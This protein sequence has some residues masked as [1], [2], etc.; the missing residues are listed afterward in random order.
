MSLLTGQPASSFASMS[1]PTGTPFPSEPDPTLVRSAGVRGLAG[2]SP[3]QISQLEELLKE[4]ASK[5]K[6]HEQDAGGR[7]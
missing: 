2:L 1:A 6:Q 7:G 4:S 3:D 5:K